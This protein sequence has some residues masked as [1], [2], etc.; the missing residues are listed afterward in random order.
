MSEDNG[1][2]ERQETGPEEKAAAADPKK[3]AP[4]QEERDRLIRALQSQ[5]L[6]RTDPLSANLEMLC[7]DLV[8][9]ANRVNQALAK[10]SPDLPVHSSG[11]KAFERKA[12]LSLKL[13]RQIDRFANLQRQQAA[14]DTEE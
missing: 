8:A 10:E 9:C 4:T 11:Y 12:D 5:A 1:A 14:K 3:S 13:T 2:N 7:A 6:Q